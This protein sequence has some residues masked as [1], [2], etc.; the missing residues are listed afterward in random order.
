MP[1]S[2]QPHQL[3]IIITYFFNFEFKQFELLKL[4]KQNHISQLQ[5]M[6]YF[7][8]FYEFRK[9]RIK[10]K[11]IGPRVSTNRGWAVGT[12]WGCRSCHISTGSRYWLRR[13]STLT[14]NP[15]SEVLE[16]TLVI[17][18]HVLHRFHGRALA[19]LRSLATESRLFPRQ[20]TKGNGKVPK[21]KTKAKVL[22]YEY[23]KMTIH[24][25]VTQASL[26]YPIS[27]TKFFKS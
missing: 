11:S 7:L 3:H 19:N 24:L 5:F 15:Q 23:G 20:I 2:P 25:Y 22:C 8:Y 4:M 17:Y 10:E 26:L 18:V 14:L 6:I 1:Y 27:L 21:E 16:E 9:D 12:D 13:V